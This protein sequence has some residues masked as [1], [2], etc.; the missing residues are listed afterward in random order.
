M[1]TAK[2]GKRQGRVIQASG[3]QV[4]VYTAVRKV[5]G[6]DYTYFRISYFEPGNG[7][8]VRDFSE[9]QAAVAEAKSIAA[10]IAAGRFDAVALT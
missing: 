3:V 2:A 8:R 7:R 5:G 10:R 4:L 6:K 9:E 1:S